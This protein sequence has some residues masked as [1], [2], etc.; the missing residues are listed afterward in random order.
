MSA[1]NIAIAAAAGLLTIGVGAT[2]AVGVLSHQQYAHLDHGQ[3]LSVTAPPRE[4]TPA[5]IDVQPVDNNA[6]NAQ[7]SGLAADPALGTMHGIVTDST[8]GE[9]IWSQNPDGALTPASSTKVLTAAAAVLSLREDSVLTTEVVRGQAPGSVVI[10]A[11]GDVWLTPEKIDELAREIK[12]TG[13]NVDTVA[14]DTSLWTGPTI[15]EGWDPTN[16]DGGYVAPLE[17]AMIYGG[18]IGA[19]E[20]DAPRSHTPAVDVAGALAQRLG[21][22][23]VGMGPAPTGADP[24]ASVDSPPLSERLKEMLLHSDNVMAE[25]IGREVAL[26]RGTGNSADAATR[27]TLEILTEAGFDTSE[28]TLK[29]NSGLSVD[30]KIRPQLLSDIL[31]AGATG[32]RLR[33]LLADLPVASGDGTLENRYLDMPGRGWV[34]AKTGTL[35]GVNALAGSVTAKS[36]RVYTFAFI[37]NDA[38]ITAGRRA[39]DRMAS[40]LRE[41]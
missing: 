33:P 2:A 39:L 12:A 38:D 21:A 25:A 14:V 4:I 37:S 29:D 28:T 6:L 35:T 15:L 16:V 30:N 19:S 41:A 11:A 32:E 36:G 27:A 34:R 23:T 1:K 10:R 13:M 3:P 31:T 9:V 7:L 18:R 22:P 24:I 8:S 17:P 40:A 26:G 5:G 20:G